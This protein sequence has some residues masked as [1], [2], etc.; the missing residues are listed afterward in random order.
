[1]RLTAPAGHRTVFSAV[2]PGEVPAA[3]AQILQ[4]LDLVEAG[5]GRLLEI[6]QAEQQP[7][8]R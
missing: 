8:L 3:S 2:S 4:P 5:G 6:A 1:M 7:P